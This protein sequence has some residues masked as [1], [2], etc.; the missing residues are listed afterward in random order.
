MA[1]KVLAQGKTEPVYHSLSRP[2]VTEEEPAR[3]GKGCLGSRAMAGDL[4]MEDVGKLFDKDGNS[5]EYVLKKIPTCKLP[6]P[7]SNG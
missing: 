1:N 6:P 5:L 4:T 7:Y 3:F 2:P